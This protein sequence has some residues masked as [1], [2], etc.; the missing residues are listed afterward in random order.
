[1]GEV[2]P[3]RRGFLGALAA[4]A[5]VRPEA[6]TLVPKIGPSDYLAGITD[7][8][9]VAEVWGAS[10]LSGDLLAEMDDHNRHLSAH[11]DSLR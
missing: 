11:M 2:R 6:V 5:V 1:V 8:G 9:T 3:T 7:G 10:A 4:V